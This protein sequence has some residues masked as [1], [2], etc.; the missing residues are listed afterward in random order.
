MINRILAQYT[1]GVGESKKFAL[2]GIIISF[3]TGISNLIFLVGLEF[4]LVGYFWS[5]IIAYS[6]ATIFLV[7]W[8]KQIRVISIT[9]ISK[10]V[11]KSLLG[12]SIPLIP[13]S[14]MWWLIN[15]SSR[16]FINGFVGIAANGVFAVSSRI[17]ALIN[18]VSQIFSQAWQLSAFEEVGEGSNSSFYTRIYELY[19][20]VLFIATSVFIVVMK[21]LLALIFSVEFFNAWQPAPFLLLGTVFSALSGFVGVAYTATKKTKGVFKTSIYGGISSLL[22]NLLFIPTTGIIGAG[23]SSMISFFIM[24]IIRY[25]DTKDLVF[26]DINWKKFYSTILVILI[27]SLI[28]FMNFSNITEFLLSLILFFIILMINRKAFE[29]ISFLWNSI[30][31]IFKIKKKNRK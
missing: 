16:Y 7:I 9:S 19:S 4:G 15:G 22:M 13:N 12:Y 1:R 10:E 20:S 21:P 28:L 29:V 23:F 14:V 24:F 31:D 5:Y 25:F 17:P 8:V 2:N 26:L 27:Q 11:G 30:K 6:L 3:A 18:V